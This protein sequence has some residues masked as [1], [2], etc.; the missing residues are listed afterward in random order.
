MQKLRVH[1]C[2]LHDYSLKC[3]QLSVSPFEIKSDS[4]EQQINTRGGRH[5]V[6][7]V[8]QSLQVQEVQ[9]SQRQLGYRGDVP[10]HIM[11]VNHKFS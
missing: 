2:Q 4:G 8:P 1:V 9:F 11:V 6:L 3:L 10:D 5:Q 7:Q